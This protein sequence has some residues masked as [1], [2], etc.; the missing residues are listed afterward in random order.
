MLH[1][2]DVNQPVLLWCFCEPGVPCRGAT[3]PGE[4][5]ELPP[6]EA[7][8]WGCYLKIVLALALIRG[9]AGKHQEL[10]AKTL[11]SNKIPAQVNI[12]FDWRKKASLPSARCSH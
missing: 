5:S 11:V 2:P 3:L 8:D 9:M 4:Q 6:K 1:L 7:S 12:V 10:K